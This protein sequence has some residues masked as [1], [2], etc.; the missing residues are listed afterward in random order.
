MDM[1]TEAGIG[2]YVSLT[3]F[4]VALVRSAKSGARLEPWAT[5]IVA[6][7]ALGAGLGQRLVARAAE[8]APTLPEKVTILSIGTREATANLVV[9]AMFALVLLIV[10]AVSAAMKAREPA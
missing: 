7:G 2:A 9:A 1:F 3:L 6:T 10:M 4:I 5:A 8:L